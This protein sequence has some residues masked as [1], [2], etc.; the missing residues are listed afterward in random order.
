MWRVLFY[1]VLGAVGFSAANSPYLMR[2]SG[3]LVPLLALLPVAFYLATL[4]IWLC[5]LWPE[6]PVANANWRSSGRAIDRSL[7]FIA[8][9][10]FGVWIAPLKGTIGPYWADPELAAID[11]AILGTDAWRL[12]HSI[13]EPLTTPM[14]YL[15]GT[16]PVALSLAT[17]GIALF[18]DERRLAR[19][20]SAM[21]LA[22]A[23]QGV[24]LAHWL[25]S[26]GPVFGPD[27]GFGF[28]DL[29]HELAAHAPYTTAARQYLWQSYSTGSTRIGSGI[30]AAPSMHCALTFILCF[31]A[32]RTRWF[33]PAV[34][35]AAFIWIG[36]V[37]L[38]WHYFTDGLISLA[39]DVAIWS[40][41]AVVIQYPGAITTMPWKSPLPVGE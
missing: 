24:V 21:A 33:V 27:L 22:W 19:F 26:A 23:L 41:V 15:Y 20:A 35:Y 7:L 10:L 3:G 1:G 18:A 25:A 39:G 4:G 34:A 2:A 28:E 36:S 40:V 14:D 37:H 5:R 38:G 11:R 30:S 31:T 32:W 13:F 29:R 9:S 12:T 8:I 17:L 16:W 6:S